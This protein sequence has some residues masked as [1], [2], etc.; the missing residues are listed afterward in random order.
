MS[1]LLAS[2]DPWTTFASVATEEML[3]EAEAGVQG[4]L[5]RRV[6]RDATLARILWAHYRSH[7]STPPPVHVT[8]APSQ[9][10]TGS[11]RARLC[12]NGVRWLP[13]TSAAALASVDDLLAPLFARHLPLSE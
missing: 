9:F 1:D 11:M 12:W 4:E 2:T 5:L 7:A 3:A 10:G 8:D 6:G 13:N